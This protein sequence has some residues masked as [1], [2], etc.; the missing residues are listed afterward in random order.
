MILGILADDAIEY[1]TD[2]HVTNFK[3]AL[4]AWF[5]T[6]VTIIKVETANLEIESLK[7]RKGEDFCSY[8]NCIK[9]FL[10]EAGGQ[11]F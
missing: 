7:Y 11:D 6:Y 2:A 4:I 10:K 3:G 1:P 5:D 8:Y 9:R